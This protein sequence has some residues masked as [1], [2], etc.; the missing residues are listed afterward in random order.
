MYTHMHTHTCIHPHTH[1]Q[2]LR[3]LA[4]SESLPG[5]LSELKVHIIRNVPSVGPHHLLVSSH[6]PWQRSVAGTGQWTTGQTLPPLP[7]PPAAAG[8]CGPELGERE[9][10]DRE[11]T[12]QRDTV[13]RST[14]HAQKNKLQVPKAC[15]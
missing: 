10:G 7:L 4:E 14:I 6:L 2:S 15:T 13:I 9:G 5:K 8:L 12:R 11:I 1:L 3:L